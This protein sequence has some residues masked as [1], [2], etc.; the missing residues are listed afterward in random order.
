[1]KNDEA[2][3]LNITSE[4]ITN[5]FNFF[6]IISSIFINIQKK[7]PIINFISTVV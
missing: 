6:S 4:E 2:H 5:Y 1:M 7:M 3:K